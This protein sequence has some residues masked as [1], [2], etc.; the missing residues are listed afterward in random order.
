MDQC[1]KKIIIHVDE[2]QTITELSGKLQQYQSDIYLQ[3]VAR[4]NVLEVN[5]KSF[6]GLV[7]L[8]LENGDTIFVRAVGDD[9]EQALEAVVEFLT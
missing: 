9:C 7:T 3:K 5:V 6:L 2:T 1:K 4:G 8:H